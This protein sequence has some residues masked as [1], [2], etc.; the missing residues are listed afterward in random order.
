[1]ARFMEFVMQTK[2]KE[3][4]GKHRWRDKTMG[5]PAAANNRR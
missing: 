2:T 5:G 4:G 3:N 1:M